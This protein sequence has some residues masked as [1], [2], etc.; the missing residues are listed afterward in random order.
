M[1]KRIAE[2]LLTIG[3]V[4]VSSFPLFS[5]GSQGTIQGAVLDSTG[6]YIPGATVT[7]LDVERGTTRALTSDEAG[8][9][10]ATSLT[11]GTYRVRAEL[12]GFARV[13]R[14]NVLGPQGT[15]N[16]INLTS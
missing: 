7:V 2:F 10:A 5:Q 1:T 4:L 15:N 13:E 14:R 16:G 3:L 9:Y 8:Q 11:A 12:A 6:A